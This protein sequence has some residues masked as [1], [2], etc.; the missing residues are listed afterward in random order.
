[1]L[2]STAAQLR[3][4]L[5]NQLYHPDSPSSLL[6]FAKGT[7][8]RAALA[9]R[10]TARWRWGFFSR[11]ALFFHHHERI[12]RFAVETL[13]PAWHRLRHG[14]PLEPARLDA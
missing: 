2:G 6:F 13:W 14:R 4:A 11:A 10:L 12:A 9:D 5:L 7:W 3:W 1:M 8:L